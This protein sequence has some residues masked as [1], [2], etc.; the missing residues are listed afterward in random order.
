MSRT[1]LFIMCGIS[2]SGKTTLAKKMIKKLPLEYIGID[3][4]IEEYKKQNN[5]QSLPLTNIGWNEVFK[6]A[7]KEISTN[8]SNRRNV[9]YDSSNQEKECRKILRDLANRHVAYTKVIYINTPKKV[10]ISRKEEN[11]KLASRQHIT[12]GHFNHILNTLEVPTRDE[13]VIVYRE[14]MDFD[15]WIKDNFNNLQ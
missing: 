10:A 11:K 5:S 2:F 14:S 12:D 8:L 15:K 7:F 1:N 6:K 9:L 13:D 3:E 4:I